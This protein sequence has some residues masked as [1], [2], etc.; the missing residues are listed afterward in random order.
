[1]SR[2]RRTFY[3]LTNSPALILAYLSI[4]LVNR[5]ELS[6]FPEPPPSA[7]LVPL[8]HLFMAAYVVV[9]I[10]Y[11]SYVS[12]VQAQMEQTGSR[13]GTIV[14]NVIVIYLLCIAAA[15]LAMFA[16]YSIEDLFRNGLTHLSIWHLAAISIIFIVWSLVRAYIN[17]VNKHF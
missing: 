14:F 15:V 16:V 12:G 4:W 11:F 1:M 5:W 3:F 8:G 6:A 13:G 7:S 2:L 9:T 10:V 17:F